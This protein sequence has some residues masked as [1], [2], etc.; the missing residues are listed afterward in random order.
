[1]SRLKKWEEKSPLIFSVAALVLYM[2]L[3]FLVSVFTTV[4]VKIEDY[5][6]SLAVNEALEAVLSVVFLIVLGRGKSV[7]KSR[8]GFFG[9]LFVGMYEIV[10][11]ALTFS[12]VCYINA[13][14]ELESVGSIIA[15]IVCMLLVGVTEEVFFR[16]V[17]ADIILENYGKDRKGVIFSVAVSGLLFGLS[18]ISNLGAGI[19]LS[20]VLIQI[21]QAAILGMFFGA[22]Y[23]RTHN[24]FGVIFLHAAMDFVALSSSGLWGVGT[25]E[26]SIDGLGVQNLVSLI[27]YLIPTIFIMRF[28]KIDEYIAQREL[29]QK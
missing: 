8:K 22:V 1:M 19:G 2:I 17:V 16:G 10:L 23:M 11:L 4:F 26:S 14:E 21:A 28:S 7:F 5:Y 29:P 15:F 18:H 3:F 9:S 6:L 25:V 20:G 27:V 24:I 13:E 12:S